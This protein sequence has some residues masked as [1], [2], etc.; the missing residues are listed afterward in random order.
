MDSSDHLQKVKNYHDKDSA[1]YTDL[2]YHDASC[3]GLAY[4]TRKKLILELVN[5]YSGKVLDVGCGPG[6]LTRELLNRKYKVYSI[7]LS[8]EMLTKAKEI[9]KL[10]YF[11]SNAHFAVSD[12][13]MMCFS[14]NTFDIVL[15]IG[16][17]Y[18]IFNYNSLIDEIKRVLRPKGFVIIQIN[19]IMWPSI[20][21]KF[22]PIYQY[23]KSKLTGKKYNDINFKFNIFSYKN[24]IADL[25]ERGFFVIDLLY[26]DYRIP[27]FDILFPR[28]SVKLGKIMFKNRGSKL[29]KYFAHGLLIKGAKT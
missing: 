16:V 7:D 18:Y 25:K 8:S 5:H 19:K 9:S 26:Y 11:Y 14:E 3:E 6:I 17:I 20:Y 21:E 22:I 27:F 29:L 1:Q 23:C 24:F 12:S 10:S 15:C 28:L 13:S 4:V 2:R